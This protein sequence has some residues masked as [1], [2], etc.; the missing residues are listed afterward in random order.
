[1]AR[2]FCPRHHVCAVALFR[3]L[4]KFEMDF[5]VNDQTYFLSLAE[6]DKRWLFFV[7]TPDGAMSIP[8]Y[9]D[10]A[11]GRPLVVLQEEKHR[12]PN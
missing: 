11:E 4:E 1:V 10:A 2:A 3:V 12:V 7:S 5:Q 6:D 8:V 9:E